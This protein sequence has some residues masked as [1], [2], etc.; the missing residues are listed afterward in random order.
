MSLFK[1]NLLL[2]ISLAVLAGCVKS[3]GLEQLELGHQTTLT[4]NWNQ[5]VDVFTQAL[6]IATDDGIFMKAYSR[7][8]EAYLWKGQNDIA[9]DDCNSAIRAKPGNNGYPYAVRG[10]L[11]AR[12][13]QDEW[14]LEDYDAAIILGGSV[15]NNAKVIAYGGKARVFA[16]SSDPDLRNGEL[17]VQF[18][19][20]AVEFEDLIDTPAYKILNRD[21]LAAAYAEAG[22][23]NDAVKEQKSTI[24][25]AT[26]NGWAGFTYNNE[27]FMNILKLHL[28]EFERKKP[29]RD[30]IF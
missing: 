4:G 6:N 14:A 26:E 23:F 5:S 16:T 25:L 8:C 20:K 12:M 24:A 10:R 21:T 2:L 29:L 19:E 1:T 9:M 7:R 18:A 15:G 13:G 3:P 11:F 28:G 30:S 22:R 17:S 27:P